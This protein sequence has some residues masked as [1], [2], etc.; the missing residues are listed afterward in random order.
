M[1]DIIIALIF[2]CLLVSY[3]YINYEINHSITSSELAQVFIVEQNQTAKQISQQL[4]EHGLINSNF[5]FR[6]YLWNKGL[7]TKLQTGK[8][9]LR[10]NMSIAEIVHTLTTNQGVLKEKTVTVFEGMTS[11]EIED[12]LI[13]QGFKIEKGEIVNAG[14]E[15]YLFP[16]TYRF[17][18]D[19]K[20][21][22]IIKKMSDNFTNQ[23]GRT[24]DHQIVILA[25]IIQKEARDYTEM[26]RI[27]GIF[28]NRLYKNLP[29]QSDATINYITGKNLRQPSIDDTK[30]QSSY[31]TYLNLGLPPGPICNPGLKAIRAAQNPETTSYFYFLHPKNGP[32][33]FSQTSKE[34]LLN[35]KEYLP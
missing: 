10:L 34:H 6:I 35:K 31:N 19:A 9:L 18:D 32:T 25:S 1:K 21:E 28:Y 15:G 5:W 7:E 4:A 17:Y 29:L 24:I 22:D 16:D 30:T 14:L 2:I 13:N 27:A 8:Y 33:V 3:F 26:R 11:A 23:V 20:A 12:L